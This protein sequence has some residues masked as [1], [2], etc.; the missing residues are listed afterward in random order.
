MMADGTVDMKFTGSAQDLERAIDRLEKKYEKLTGQIK[1]GQRA[2]RAGGGVVADMQKW[3][4]SL[5]SITAAYQM[6]ASGIKSALDY[7]RELIRLSDEAGRKQDA[8]TRTFAAN[9]GIGRKQALV[10][11]RQ[12]NAVAIKTATD[13]PLVQEAASQL[14]GSGFTWQEASGG[15]AEALLKGRAVTGGGD[16]GDLGRNAAMALNAKG[17]D[18]TAANVEMLMSSIQGSRAAGNLE[19]TTLQF[20]SRQLSASKRP[21]QEDLALANLLQ[22][23]TTEEPAATAFGSFVRTADAPKPKQLKAL[24][25]AGLLTDDGKHFKGQGKS[26]GEMLN[27]Y[28]EAV[29]K[30]PE[31]DKGNF[32]REIF[33][34]GQDSTTIRAAIETRSKFKEKLAAANDTKGYKKTVG[35]F[36]GGLEFAAK[37]GELEQEQW[38]A[39]QVT[40][41]TTIAQQRDMQRKMLGMSPFRSNLIQ[42]AGGW[43]RAAGLGADLGETLAGGLSNPLAMLLGSNPITASMAGQ[44]MSAESALQQA[45]DAKAARIVAERLAEAMEKNNALLEQQQA[46]NPKRPVA[47]KVDE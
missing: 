16:A 6:I 32:F 7:Q 25:K 3:A 28:G 4:A 19:S 13:M 20:L 27:I 34:A 40:P 8:R 22:D 41:G 47:V 35:D 10:A 5:I 18:K 24:K 46:K 29:D 26:F 45:T 15:A 23:V 43:S 38:A 14:V 36:F 17:L 42:S 44:S 11:E 39:G 33:G 1:A 30:M 37:A 2:A 9:A 21:I 12:M 31:A